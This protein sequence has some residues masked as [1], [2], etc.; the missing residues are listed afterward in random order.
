M[1]LF[2]S[3]ETD[4]PC[5]KCGA[6]HVV[7]WKDYPEKDKSLIEC[8]KPGCD[9]IVIECRGTREYWRARLKDSDA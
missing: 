8:E 5:E 2:D 3:G 9:G 4:M 7:T 6:I 1:A